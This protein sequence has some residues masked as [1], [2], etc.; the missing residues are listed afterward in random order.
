MI[1]II[2][3]RALQVLLAL[4]MMRVATT[5]LSP[6]EF[7]K[8]ALVLTTVSFFALF[9]VNPIGMFINRR[10]H[11]WCTE[12]V[13]RYYL[14]RYLRYLLVINMISAVLLI[15]LDL[16]FGLNLGL[17][18]GWLILLVC[19]SLFFNTINQTS[20]PSLNML[21]NSKKFILLSTASLASSLVFASLFVT[22]LAPEAQYW[23]LGLLIGQTLF[24]IIG[25]QLL[26]VQ[27]HEKYP[28]CLS[29]KIS[30]RHL[31][32][33]FNF[34]WPVSIAAG[35]SWMHLQGY[36][37]VIDAGLGLSDLGLFVAGYGI[38]AGLI[39]A[40][41]SVLMTYFQPRLYRDV[42]DADASQQA[43]AWQQYAAVIIPSIILTAGLSI[44]LAPELAQI[45]LG[46]DFQ[47]SAT[48]IIWGAFAELCRVLIGV[49]SLNAHIHMRTD[50]LIVPN[51]IGAVLSIVLI[52]LLIPVMGLAGAGIGL[53]ASGGIVVAVM[54]IYLV[55]P[56]VKGLPIQPTFMAGILSVTLWVIYL[57][58]HHFLDSKS[59]ITF[60]FICMVIGGLYLGMQYLFLRPHLRDRIAF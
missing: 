4:I 25:T 49:Y 36:R 43:K 27:L 12:G 40:S 39:A 6:A 54:H 60:C 41:E 18:I 29:P 16:V 20:I 21:G 37:Y 26:F 23:L 47:S 50:W 22:F 3:G 32:K 5:L 33:L 52:Q 51:L 24:A 31:K 46:K 35:L 7:G 57:S 14:M 34:A 56:N 11:S 30:G 44:V 9:L 55:A 42:S 17:P 28:L 19:G 58:L 53:V 10:L 59:L 2:L 8:I 48:F 1:F 13:F 38:S 45:L 15:L